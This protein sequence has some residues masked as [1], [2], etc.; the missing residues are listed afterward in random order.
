MQTGVKHLLHLHHGRPLVHLQPLDLRQDFLLGIK[1]QHQMPGT[2]PNKELHLL[3]Q[4]E[5]AAQE[6]EE[7]LLVDPLHHLTW[8]R[9]MS[10]ILGPDTLMA[11]PGCQQI[12]KLSARLVRSSWTILSMALET[13]TWI[14]MS[15]C[16]TT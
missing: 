14:G 6:E 4:E 12:G 13:S 16:A 7:T 11:L 1:A 3:P 5:P 2:L 9:T 10:T 15:S 8:R